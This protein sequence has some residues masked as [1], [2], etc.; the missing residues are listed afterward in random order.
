MARINLYD[1]AAPIELNDKLLGTEVSANDATK[2]FIVGG[3]L[4]LFNANSVPST[5]TSPGTQGQ[6]AA[7]ANYLYICVDE[8]TWRRVA[9][10]TF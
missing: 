3:L 7:D 6:I 2:N 8:N 4:A 10:S 1:T 5:N 9:L